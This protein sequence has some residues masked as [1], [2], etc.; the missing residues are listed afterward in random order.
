M[1]LMTKWYTVLSYLICVIGLIIQVNEVSNNYFKY[2]TES[3]IYI[4]TH[5]V[6]SAPSMSVCF[7]KSDILQRDEIKKKRGI[8][9][10]KPSNASGWNIYRDTVEN[11][12]LNMLFDFTPSERHLLNPIKG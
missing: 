3:K 4:T 7:R 5:E 10:I 12:T 6:I 8:N 11:F 2:T 1:Y 9:L